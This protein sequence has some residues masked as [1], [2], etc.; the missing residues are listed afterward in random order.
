MENFD[1]LVVSGSYILR[2]QLKMLLWNEF[3]TSVV[4]AVATAEEGKREIQRLAE[5][6][7]EF[8]ILILEFD[9]WNEC[10][11]LCLLVNSEFP[12]ALVVH[13]EAAKGENEAQPLF[14]HLATLH[15]EPDTSRSLVISKHDPEW[16][17]T[18]LARLKS[19]LYERQTE[20][21]SGK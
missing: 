8:D 11:K 2:N 20:I 18:L 19:Y 9:C 10:E 5:K 17:T 7:R 16:G 1:I 15:T 21:V 6:G 3:R 4:H 14:Q 13:L 12:D